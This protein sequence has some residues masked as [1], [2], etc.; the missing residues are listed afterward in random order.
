[1]CAGLAADFGLTVETAQSLRTTVELWSAGA[2]STALSAERESIAPLVSLE[3]HKVRGTGAWMAPEIVTRHVEITTKA[4]VYSFGVVLWELVS[5]QQDLLEAWV[6]QTAAAA[7]RV[8]FSCSENSCDCIRVLV[9]G[10]CCFWTRSL[11]ASRRD[12]S[13]LGRERHS[14]VHSC[15]CARAGAWLG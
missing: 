9:V 1:M 13:N 10:D 11:A 4:D 6:R 2:G 14:S 3:D 7:E 12:H 5:P 15:G 8:A